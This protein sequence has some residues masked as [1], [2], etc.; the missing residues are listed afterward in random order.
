MSSSCI[1]TKFGFNPSRSS[2]EDFQRFLIFLTNLKTWQPSLIL[3]KVSGHT[4]GRGAFKEYHIKVWS[5]LT[6]WFL[7]ISKSENM[8][9]D[10]HKVMG[11]ARL[12]RRPWWTKNFLRTIKWTLLPCLSTIGPVV[13]G[14]RL[15]CKSLDDEERWTSSNDN[16]SH[17]P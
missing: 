15:K 16:T 9:D 13:L 5:N 6:L 11:K 17:N 3:G 8:T 2:E 10:R 14:K 1:L 12:S 7:R 4:F